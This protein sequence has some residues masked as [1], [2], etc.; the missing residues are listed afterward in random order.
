[1][2]CTVLGSGAACPPAG[3]NSSGILIN[4]QGRTILLDTGHGVASAVLTA[5]PDFDI[6]DIII[7]HMHADHFIDVLALRF[8]VTRDMDGLAGAPPRTT[9]HLPPGGIDT[10]E[11]ILD[12]VTFPTDFCRNTFH[13]REYDPTE[14]CTLGPLTVRFAAA[15]HYIPAWA[16]RVQ[17]RSIDGSDASLT[18]SGDT[19]PS[20]L[21][22]ALAH[23]TDLFLCEATLQEP[24]TGPNRG[25]STPH[26]AAAMATDARAK[27]LLL[28]HFWYGTNL[29]DVRRSAAQTYTGPLQIADDGLQIQL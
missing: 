4:D 20:D 17:G 14:T 2:Q 9:L 28:T 19:T 15:Q 11:K 21:V 25:H 24:E 1:M 22:T 3:K 12:A 26:Q 7:T 8:R 5:H 23:D 10:L 29:N 16:I 6:D 13:V 18:Y 27:R